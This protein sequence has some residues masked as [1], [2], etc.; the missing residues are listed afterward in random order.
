MFFFFFFPFKPS[1]STSPSSVPA[2]LVPCVCMVSWSVC[3]LLREP[4]KQ[5]SGGTD[6]WTDGANKLTFKLIQTSDSS[7]W[8]FQKYNILLMEKITSV[9]VAR[10]EANGMIRPIL[11]T[12]GSYLSK[13]GRSCFCFLLFSFY[14]G[15]SV[16][17]R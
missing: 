4:I 7:S 10:S 15:L 1:L 2:P 6:R 3:L 16:S 17:L 13:G 11:Y 5:R 8:Q 12:Y 9:N 14:E